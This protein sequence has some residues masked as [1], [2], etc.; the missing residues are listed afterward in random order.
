[1]GLLDRFLGPPTREKFARTV[2][3]GIH[4]AGERRQ[5]VYDSEQF[6]LRPDGDEVSVMNLTNVYAEFCATS[7]DLRPKLIT[8][9]VRNWF[10]DRRPL[11]EAFEDVHPDLLPTVRSRAYFE[12]A[13]LQMR[14]E[15]GRGLI[16]YPQQVLGDHLSIGL[17]YDLPDSMRTIVAQDLS[18][19]EV[20]FYEAL[21]AACV[22]LRQ[23]EDP[24]FL[25]PQDGVYFSATGDNYDASRMIL[26]DMMRQFD[27][28]GDIVAMVPNR[29]TLIITGTLDAIGLKIMADRA[30]QAM[31]EPRPI[32]TLAFRFENEE[33]SPWLPPPDHVAY[34]ALATLRL[35]SLGQEYAEQKNLLES[36]HGGD[37]QSP[38]IATF[39]AMQNTTTGEIRSYAIWTE[40]VDTLLPKAD[41]VH[42]VRLG[43]GSTEGKLL[44][45]CEWE[46]LETVCG[47]LLQPQ[48]LY[49]PRF[50]VREFPAAAQLAE[51]VSQKGSQ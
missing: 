38:F 22:N 34:S 35:Q 32:S 45:S 15:G 23:K 5:I 33:W 19:W 21:E 7:K 37:E 16:D 40:G 1:M 9:V 4:S 12:F 3:A 31:K 30:Q 51:L 25:S 20:T 18:E 36:V 27:V 50:R 6:C 39:S 48:D 11:P 47:S 13:S 43:R 10:A 41:L 26:L 14:A 49:P 44:A 8:N 29:D 28:R 2:M 46:H 17:V 24:V 42:L